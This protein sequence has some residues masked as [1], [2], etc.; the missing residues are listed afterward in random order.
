VE[1]DVAVHHLVTETVG[2]ITTLTYL[3]LIN[4]VEG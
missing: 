2:G 4:R 1:E 3:P